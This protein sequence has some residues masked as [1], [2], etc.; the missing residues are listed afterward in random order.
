LKQVAAVVQPPAHLGA[1]LGK[2]ARA[3]PA[4]VDDWDRVRSPVL[5]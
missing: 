5:A 3:K 4:L 1:P 2:S